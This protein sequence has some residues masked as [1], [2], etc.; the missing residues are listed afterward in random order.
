MLHLYFWNYSI[1]TKPI[2]L[3][4]GGKKECRSPRLN[5]QFLSENVCP[6]CF[7]WTFNFWCNISWWMT[8]HCLISSI[9]KNWLVKIEALGPNLHVSAI[10]STIEGCAGSPYHDHQISWLCLSGT[11]HSLGSLYPWKA[12]AYI[13]LSCNMVV[14]LSPNN[15]WHTHTSLKFVHRGWADGK[16]ET[17]WK[18]V[19]LTLKWSWWPPKSKYLLQQN[20]GCTTI[21]TWL[22]SPFWI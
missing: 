12:L 1:A 11:V 14:R 21:H 10:K 22:L 4:F 15:H 17:M 9:L 19:F 5:V 16:R 6:S 8:V 7:N 2:A 18:R 13:Q 20:Q 3:K